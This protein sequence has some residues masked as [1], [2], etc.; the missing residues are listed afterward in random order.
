MIT[1]AEPKMLK[2]KNMTILGLKLLPNNPENLTQ[3]RFRAFS[4]DDHLSAR[5]HL[6]DHAVFAKVIKCLSLSI[7]VIIFDKKGAMK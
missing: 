5:F 6:H 1:L 2:S 4:Q 7:L 3:Q